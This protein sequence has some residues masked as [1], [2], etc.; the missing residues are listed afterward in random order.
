V[1]ISTTRVKDRNTV[2]PVVN[3]LIDPDTTAGVQPVGL[4]GW[5]LAM[6]EEFNGTPNITDAT[7]GYLNFRTGGPTWSAWYPNWSMFTSQSPGGNHTNTDQAAYYQADQIATSGSSLQLSINKTATN[8][9]AYRAGMIQSLQSFTPKY[10]FFEAKLRIDA[11][12]TGVWPAW[13]M[14]TSVTNTWPPE[15]DIAEI[16]DAG[17]GILANIFQPSIATYTQKIAESA[18]A[19][20]YHTYGCSWT[21]SNVTF[22][23]DGVNVGGRSTNIPNTNQYLIMNA[24]ARIPASPTFS[25]GLLEVDYIRAWS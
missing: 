23:L 16:Y 10:G 11:V 2:E 18:T 20:T 22:Y 3:P 12:P 1:I 7:N 8:G 14:S 4:S 24:G 5:T 21:A 17:T 6:S 13:W 19:T 25:T 9:M 15:I